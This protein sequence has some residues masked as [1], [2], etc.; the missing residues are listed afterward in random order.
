MHFGDVDREIANGITFE[1]L[2]G[3]F[4]VLDAGQTG[5]AMTL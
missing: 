2:L 5:D 3:R 1:L 4:I